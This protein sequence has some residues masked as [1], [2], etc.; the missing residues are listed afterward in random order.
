MSPVDYSKCAPGAEADE[1]LAR[2]L[3]RLAEE[4][5][6]LGDAREAN[7]LRQRAKAVREGL[8]PR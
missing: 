7:E 1:F 8:A 4:R 2:D 6:D 5:A 3:E